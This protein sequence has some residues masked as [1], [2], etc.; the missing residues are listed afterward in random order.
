MTTAV[1]HASQ[2]ALPPRTRAAHYMKLY[3]DDLERV[4]I[5]PT[6]KRSHKKPGQCLN[7]DRCGHISNQ[8]SHPLLF[9]CVFRSRVH[10]VFISS[11]DSELSMC[12]FMNRNC[13]CEET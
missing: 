12:K 4:R 1:T 6:K 9:A 2:P 5:N 7:P 10:G 3:E 11:V 13:L 8:N